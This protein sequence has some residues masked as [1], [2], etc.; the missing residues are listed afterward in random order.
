[1]LDNVIND[2]D[3]TRLAIVEKISPES[4]YNYYIY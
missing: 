2:T 3:A 4:A 1:M